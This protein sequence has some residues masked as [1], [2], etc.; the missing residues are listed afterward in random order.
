M[1][2][3]LPIAHAAATAS[4]LSQT[5]AAAAP[6]SVADTSRGPLSSIAAASHHGQ[7]ISS[8]ADTSRHR[9]PLPPSQPPD[10]AAAPPSV[11][12]DSQGTTSCENLYDSCSVKSAVQ[13]VLGAL[14]LLILPPKD[15]PFS[16]APLA[17]VGMGGRDQALAGTDDSI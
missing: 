13:R 11:T 12:A 10:A 17:V 6:P 5:P 7:P 4:P 16:L 14:A 8:I 1:V 15:V 9:R 2:L 3:D